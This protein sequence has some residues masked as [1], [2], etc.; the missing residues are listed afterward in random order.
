MPVPIGFDST[1]DVAGSGAALGA[2]P[3]G[4][5]RGPAPPGRR[6]ARRCGSCG[7]RP[8]TPPASA[9]TSAAA[10]EDRGDG[11]DGHALGE[12]GDVQREHD[13]PAHG[14]HVAARVGGGDGAE[15]GRV[16]DERR[17]E[18]GRRH[19]RRGRRETGRRRRRRT[20]PARR[21][22]RS[23]PDDRPRTRPPA[24]RPP[25]WPRTR[26]TR[27]TRSGEYPSRRLIARQAMPMDRSSRCSGHDCAKQSTATAKRLTRW[28]VWPEPCLDSSPSSS[29]PPTTASAW[30]SSSSTPR[31]TKPTW[32]NHPEH[33]VAQQRGRAEW[34]AEYRIQVCQLMWE[35]TF[36]G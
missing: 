21:A 2:H 34:Y 16:V 30:R 10:C 31:S 27:S 26:R 22:G 29:S 35:H 6:S 14:E 7:R 36:G 1:S 18:V 17:E 24:A 28:S 32:R 20:G 15:V 11:L 23:A 3:V 19:Q 12:G 33:R 8:T 25:T 9:T 5:R 13:P 4:M